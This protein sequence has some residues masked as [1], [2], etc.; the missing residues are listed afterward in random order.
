MRAPAA[1]ERVE[2]MPSS[3]RAAASTL[4][5]LVGRVGVVAGRDRRVGGEDRAL[6]GGVERLLG[7]APASRRGARELEA[8]ERGVALVEVHDAR[9]D[10]E[11]AAARARRR[12]PSSAYC[13]SRTSGS[14]TY[15]REVI[16]RSRDAVLGP[17]GVEQQQR[18][19]A[20]VDAPD[21]GDDLALADRHG[22]RQRLAVLAGD[23]RGGHAVG[24][25]VDPVLVLPAGGVDALA[26]VAV[27]V[28]QADRDERQ[29][30]GP[31]PP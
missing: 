12:S 10:A 17:V 14:P 5:H 13:A 29:P 20:D 22:D 24:I 25:G 2:S 15:R 27:A 8:G 9:V 11:R 30:R 19:A 28:H 1:H 16:Q 4:G 31:R 23:E 7:E 18:H 6:A 21:L 3:P 26:E